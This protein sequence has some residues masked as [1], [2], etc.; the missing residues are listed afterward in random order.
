MTLPTKQRS[1]KEN[2]YLGYAFE[3]P[4]PT[5]L[6]SREW[7]PKTREDREIPLSGKLRSTY[8]EFVLPARGGWIQ[9]NSLKAYINHL[10]VYKKR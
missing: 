6:K 2:C 8:L 5:A 9:F 7:N 10:K 3:L 1:L 4:G